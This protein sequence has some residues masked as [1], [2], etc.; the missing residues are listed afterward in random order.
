[1]P[2]GATAINDARIA[3]PYDDAADGYP[4]VD[5][6]NPVDVGGAQYLADVVGDLRADFAASTGATPDPESNSL[7]VSVG[8]NISAAPFESAVYK[9]EPTLE[10]L[11][12]LGLQVSSVGNHEFDRG[13]AELLRISGGAVNDA[14]TDDQGTTV[15]ACPATL[16]GEPFQPGVDGCFAGPNGATF[17]GTGY[18]MLAANV[19]YTSGVNAGEPIL[20]PY[21]VFDVP[22]PAGTTLQLGMIGVVTTTTPEQVVPTG[23]ANLTFGDEVQALDR[24]SGE[25]AGQGVDAIVGL[26]HEG[27]SQSAVTA[28]ATNGYQDCAGQLAGQRIGAIA[29]AASTRIDALLTGHSHVPYN[30]TI[31]DPAG[32]DR[33][34][35]QAGFYGKAVTDLRLQINP[36]TGEIDRASVTA[37]NVPVARLNSD[38]AVAAVSDYWLGEAQADGNVPAGSITADINRARDANGAPVRDRES[39][40]GNLVADSQLA[41]LQSDPLYGDPVIAFMNPGGL[42]TDLAYAPDGQVT[43]REVFD[44]QPFSN[45]VNALTLT[46]AQIDELLEQQFPNPAGRTTQLLL[47]ASAGFSYTYDPTAGYG[48]HVEACSITLDG[49]VLD[50]QGDYRVAANS[51][52][53]PGGDGFTAFLS[54]TDVVPGPLDAQ[55]FQD[56]IIANSPVAPPAADRITVSE[57]PFVCATPTTG[58]S[59]TPGTPGIPGTQPIANPGNGIAAGNLADT[60]AATGQ[61]TALGVGLL[62][63]GGVATAAGYRRGRGVTE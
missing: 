40:L 35:T 17:D 3:N 10:I 48:S 38:P 24:Y 43:Y 47:S 41:A 8:D 16:D 61:L 2:S 14:W 44:V 45:F 18:P 28:P 13:L 19:T 50:P 60:G 12:Q 59:G 39:S 26:V 11:D 7:L 5:L 49:Q 62:V 55:T 1:M 57:E 22:G 36:T 33:K 30:C 37:Q 4:G 23:V 58:G 34:V 32:N 6:P 29:S 31:A 25:L 56:Y 21:V 53:T 27:G 42:R 63:A 46:G 15:D 9:D 52:L 51:F 20:P 54:G